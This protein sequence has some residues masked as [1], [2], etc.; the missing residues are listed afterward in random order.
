MFEKKLV[1]IIIIIIIIITLQIF[2]KKF[3]HFFAV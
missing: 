2:V 3:R 1:I